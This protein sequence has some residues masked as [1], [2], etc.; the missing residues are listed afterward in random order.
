[1]QA[2]IDGTNLAVSV[3]DTGIG[4]SPRDRERIF[5]AF[6]QVDSSLSRQE[7]GTG[8]GLTLT[9]Q[10]VELHGGRIWAESEG[11]GK[12]STFTFVIPLCTPES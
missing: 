8:L 6:E 11:L 7:Q 4:I 2:G 1:V 12:G 10:M 3:S 9:K 5:Q